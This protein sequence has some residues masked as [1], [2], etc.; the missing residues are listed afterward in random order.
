MG[1]KAFD[2]NTQVPVGRP[3]Q[4]IVEAAYA[5]R[6]IVLQHRNFSHLKRMLTPS[7][8]VGVATRSHCPT[9]IVPSPWHVRSS[10]NRITVGIADIGNS[11]QLLEVAFKNAEARLAGI[12]VVHSWKYLSATFD[13]A[14]YR[15]VTEEV[16]LDYTRQLDQALELW[17]HDF[18]SVTV[19]Q[20]IV[21]GNAA[22]ALIGHSKNSDLL[23]VGR[24]DTAGPL[25][26]PLGM[27][28]RKVV[29]N[30]HCPVEVVPYRTTNRRSQRSHLDRSTS[31]D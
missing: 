9:V 4:A 31:N 19:E 24:R 12:D 30:S 15:A 8:S 27:V 20:Y 1:G 25:P 10:R 7:T 2:V 22:E 11:A 6:L 3:H 16:R 14:T 13:T 21:R 28:A 29:N 5:A 17:R 18:P 26:L 23:I